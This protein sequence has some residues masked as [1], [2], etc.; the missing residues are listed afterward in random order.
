MTDDHLYF[1]RRTGGESEQAQQAADLRVV[2][3]HVQLAEA[4][5]GHIDAPTKDATESRTT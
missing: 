5:F 1:Y 4:Y 2:R 3:A